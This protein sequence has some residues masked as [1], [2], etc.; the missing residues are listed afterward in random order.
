MKKTE[1]KIGETLQ[2]GLLTL[3]CV[4]AD[5][6]YSRCEQCFLSDCCQCMDI[7]GNCRYNNRE[8]KTDVIFKLVED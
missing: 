3:K 5:Y 8:D 6:T 7:A 1:F 4:K 2:L